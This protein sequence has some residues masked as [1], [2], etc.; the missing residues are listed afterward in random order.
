M[1]QPFII[2]I[3]I[4]SALNVM[5]QSSKTDLFD[6][7]TLKMHEIKTN[8]IRSDFGPAIIDKFIYFT[9]FRDEIIKKSDKELKEKEFYDLYKAGIDDS[10]NVTSTRQS[11]EEFITRFHDGPVS[12]CAK[13][14]EL[15]VTQSNYVDPDVVYKP[16]RNENIKLRIVIYKRQNGIWT[17][18][19]EFPFNNPKYS[20][21]H[22]AINSSGDTLIFA[23]DKP[24]GF[25]ETDLYL[26]VRMNLKWGEPTNLG[27]IVNTP[28]KEEFPFITG[29]G[30][31][32][33]FLIFASNGHNTIGGFDLFY[34]KLYES[35]NEIYRFQNP[36]NSTFDDFALIL[37]DNVEY[38]YM[39]TDRPGTGSDDIYKITFNKYREY[40]LEILILDSKTWK[41]IPGAEVDFCRK[42]IYK[43]GPD[44]LFSRKFRK[45][46][47]CD[48]KVS[49]FG[50]KDNSKSI[51]LVAPAHG[52]VLRDTIFLDM[53]V[54]EK[55]VLRNIY[56]DF[57]KW[58]ILPES[59]AEL[60]RLVALM[61]E[62]PEMKV[63]LG[64][65]TDERG[66]VPYN[67]RLSQ[68]RAESAVNYIVSKGIDP[69]KIKAIGY[70]KSQLIHM[71]SATHKCTPEEHRENRRTEIFIPGF[72]R[73]EPVKQEKGD[74]SNGR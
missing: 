47:I 60:D 68:K 55:I 62:N 65:H 8:T 7:S 35:E 26:S 64:S 59:G 14:G 16:F 4:F 63:E 25:G 32:G 48:V 3:L 10:G 43:T 13:T 21:G 6:Q 29:S 11:I 53:I 12:W 38:G 19:E 74:F 23:S 20:V 46:S 22:P 27:P 57:D 24:G 5:A 18:I 2:I 56:Y 71:S 30:Y 72:I 69:S 37:P 1:K 50:Y 49:A 54:N 70:G 28:G 34:K 66:T 31:P 45:D 42:N 44:A 36:I 33:R 58:D 9:S 40:L 41:P 67:N 51:H 52:S 39:T 17:A 61:K 73:G 15:Y